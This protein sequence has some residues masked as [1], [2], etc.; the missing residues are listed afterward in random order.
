MGIMKDLDITKALACEGFM[1][2]TELWFLA[3]WARNYKRILEIGSYMGR[4]TRALADNTEG[5]VVTVD[6]FQ[7]LREHVGTY[8]N[9]PA[10]EIEKALRRNLLDLINL[11]KVIVIKESHEGIWAIRPSFDMCFIDGSHDYDSVVRDIGTA[12]KMVPSGLICGHDFDD[13]HPDVMRAVKELMPEY[14]VVP[15]T[16]LWWV[17][18]S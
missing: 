12:K 1:S 9:P 3:T 10:E 2:E 4:S 13:I 18:I 11:A 5:Y 7:G 8:G 14:Q 16:S 17:K 6:D 15:E